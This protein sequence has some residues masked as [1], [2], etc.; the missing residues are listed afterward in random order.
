MGR[1]TR[2]GSDDHGVSRPHRRGGDDARRLETHGIHCIARLGRAAGRRRRGCAPSSGST[3]TTS[4]PG[5]RAPPPTCSRPP[6]RTGL[7]RCPEMHGDSPCRP[8]RPPTLAVPFAATRAASSAAATSTPCRLARSAHR[9]ARPPPEASG[10]GGT[11][12]RARRDAVRTA[13]HRHGVADSIAASPPA[14]PRDGDAAGHPRFSNGGGAK[15]N[16]EPSRPSPLGGGESPRK[17]PRVV[18]PCTWP[19]Q[20]AEVVCVAR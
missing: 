15:R 20:P 5:R 11:L 14:S 2:I 18:R 16:G 4:R 19:S 6:H 7:E 9:A 17:F 1:R 10:G 8:S 12:R 3:P 13:G